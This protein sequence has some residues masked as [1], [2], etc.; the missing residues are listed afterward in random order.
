MPF[1]RGLQPCGRSN[2]RGTMRIERISIQAYRSLYNVTFAPTQFTVL[3][4]PNNSGKSNLVEALDF[5]GD[6][7]QHGIEVAITRKG[8]FENIA[9]RRMRRTKR[10]IAF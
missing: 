2:A 3:V 6:V 10:P 8:G 1:A 7:H 9:H 5:L 4:G